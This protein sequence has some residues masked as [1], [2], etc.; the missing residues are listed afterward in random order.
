MKCEQLYKMSAHEGDDP[1]SRYDNDS[2]ISA[3]TWQAALHAAGSVIEA[4]DKV[5]TPEYRNAFCAVRPP[6]HHAGV[7]GKTFKSNVSHNVCD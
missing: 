1:A 6:G 2:H 4:C 7:F 3:K 5:M